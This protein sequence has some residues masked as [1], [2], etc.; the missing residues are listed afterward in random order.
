MTTTKSI[1]MAA[2]AALALTTASLAFTG[3]AA[4]KPGK[5]F[6]KFHGHGIHVRLLGHRF[7]HRHVYFKPI[8]VNPCL[9]WFP[10][11]GWVNVCKIPY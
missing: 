7:L 8:Y 9:K 3:E 2:I 6:V 1:V 11:F 5:G 10:R 4:A